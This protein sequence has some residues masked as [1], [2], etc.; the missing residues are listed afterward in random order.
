MATVVKTYRTARDD[1][2]KYYNEHGYEGTR[3]EIPS[4]LIDELE[5]LG[6]RGYTENFFDTVLTA[7]TCC[8]REEAPTR[9]FLRQL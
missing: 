3:P 7:K 5:P 6:S 9:H 4:R 1:I 8:T 2:W